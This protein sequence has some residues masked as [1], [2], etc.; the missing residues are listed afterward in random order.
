MEQ[1]DGWTDCTEEYLGRTEPVYRSM[2]NRQEYE[3]AEWH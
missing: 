3:Y 1:T 2:E